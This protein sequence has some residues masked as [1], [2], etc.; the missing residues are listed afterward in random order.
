MVVRQN[1]IR[2]SLASQSG[3]AKVS[4]GKVAALLIRTSIQ[5]AKDVP[6]NIVWNIWNEL[7]GILKRADDKTVVPVS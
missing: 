7:E 1:T 3:E 4:R 6:G 5:Y 2:A